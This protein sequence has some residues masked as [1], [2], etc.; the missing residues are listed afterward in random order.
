MIFR[1]LIYLSILVFVGL[2]ACTSSQV[3]QTMDTL[4]GLLGNDELT[5]DQVASGLKEALIA[6]ISEGSSKASK[7][8]GY[9]NN[10]TI[11]LP[12]P[13][14]VQKVETKLRQIGLG[15]EVDKFVV[16]LNRGAEEAAKEAKPIFIAAIRGMTIQ[17][18]WSILKGEENSATEYL[19]RKTSQQLQ[20]KFQPVIKRA[21]DKTSA[22]K[23][24]KDIVTTYNKIPL[25]DDVKDDL[26]G[27]AT[28]KAI[29]GLFTLIAEEERKIRVDPLAR[30]TD[31]L[32][33]VFAE[34]D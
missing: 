24:Y 4:G 33:R 2:T 1:R 10:P 26:E 19:R 5:S 7:L 32:K 20:M 14:D 12:F 30:T 23:Y 16:T 8:N 6:G 34:Q 17:D 25:V 28:N 11:K 18:A 3:S 22:T 15:S 21:L 9:F 27:Y 13:P 29:E 31:L